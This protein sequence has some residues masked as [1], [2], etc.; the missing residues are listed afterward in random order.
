MGKYIEVNGEPLRW[1]NGCKIHLP[2]PQFGYDRK[3]GDGLA[4]RCRNCNKRK[5]V[6]EPIKYVDE[7][8]QLLEALGYETDP[9]YPQTVHQQF[10]E[11]HKQKLEQNDKL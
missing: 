11:R 4:Y 10:T 9:N 1:C 3:S 5:D 7:A 2:V 6:T 8:K